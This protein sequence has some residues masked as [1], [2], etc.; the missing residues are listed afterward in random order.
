MMTKRIPKILCALLMILWGA[1][2]FAKDEKLGVGLIVGEPTG[3]SLKVWQDNVH[4]IDL[5]LGWT[6]EHNE[7]FHLHADYLFHDFLVFKPTT[8]RMP[9]YYGLG[10]S[11][12]RKSGDDTHLGIRV[13][14]GIS[15]LFADSPLEVFGEL[16][17]RADFN[18]NSHLMLD[19]A[20][21]IRFYFK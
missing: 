13:P 18:T 3:L 2:A 7:D 10:G 12:S 21:G 19:A 9:L 20:F 14:F 6:A 4:A 5:G 17:P 8:G 15:Y 1:V 16:A 11:I